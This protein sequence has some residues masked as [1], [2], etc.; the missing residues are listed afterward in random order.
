MTPQPTKAPL[1]PLEAPLISSTYKIQHGICII[2]LTRFP[3]LQGKGRGG[4]SFAFKVCREWNK[5]WSFD[6]SFSGSLA[7]ILV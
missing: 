4:G 2:S 7:H 3:L 5:S 1:L 6:S